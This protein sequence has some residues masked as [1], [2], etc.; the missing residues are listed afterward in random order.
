MALSNP[1]R[2]NRTSTAWSFFVLDDLERPQHQ[3]AMYRTLVI[4]DEPV[5]RDVNDL[6]ATAWTVKR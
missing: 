4:Q 1:N 5:Q 2:R 3:R 6:F